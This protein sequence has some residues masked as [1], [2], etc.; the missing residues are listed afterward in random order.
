M[1]PF[2]GSTPVDLHSMLYM[3]TPTG[4]GVLNLPCGGLPK[5]SIGL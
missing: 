1:Y 5:A 2:P 3:L 4:Q